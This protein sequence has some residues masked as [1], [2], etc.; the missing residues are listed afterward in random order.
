MLILLSHQALKVYKNKTEHPVVHFPYRNIQNYS[1]STLQKWIK[2]KYKMMAPSQN[3][4]SNKHSL[5]AVELFWCILRATVLKSACFFVMLHCS[6]ASMLNHAN[7]L[8]SGYFLAFHINI[9][10]FLLIE[11]NKHW[12]RPNFSKSQPSSGCNLHMV[13]NVN[14][15][16]Q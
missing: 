1:I 11:I 7:L 2:G 14:Y 5:K 10:Y 16:G 15:H 8:N 3:T 9:W 6:V 13:P 4:L 12:F